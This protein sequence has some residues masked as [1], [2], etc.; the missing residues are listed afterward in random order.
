[1]TMAEKMLAKNKGSSSSSAKKEND[2]KNSS[3]D[4]H[5][6]TVNTKFLHDVLSAISYSDPQAVVE[7]CSHAKEFLKYVVYTVFRYVT[8]N[9]TDTRDEVG[10]VSAPTLASLLHVLAAADERSVG[11]TAVSNFGG[12]KLPRRAATLHNNAAASTSAA[13]PRLLTT[14]MT[15][16][17]SDIGSTDYL[18]DLSEIKSKWSVID[19]NSKNEKNNN[20]TRSLNGISELYNI[21][22]VSLAQQIP[23]LQR[24]AKRARKLNAKLHEESAAA[25]AGKKGKKG[26]TAGGQVNPGKA[27]SIATQKGHFSFELRRMVPV[28]TP[29]YRSDQW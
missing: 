8:G 17:S 1:M 20:N 24:M 22:L 10:A 25:A 16:S 23:R 3:A 29:C 27:T 18:M 26:V 19:E 5:V 15:T 12:F 14:T 4:T 28:S 7:D 11:A 21:W 6:V 9:L 13:S 2:K